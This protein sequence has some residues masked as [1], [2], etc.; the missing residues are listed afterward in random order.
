MALV[1]KLQDHCNEP[2]NLRHTDT[3]TL[4]K[5]CDRYGKG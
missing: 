2:L 1:Q 4:K 3:T 5:V